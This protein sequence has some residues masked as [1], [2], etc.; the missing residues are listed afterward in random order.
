MY[1]RRAGP[2]APSRCH[3]NVTL[4]EGRRIQSQD[5][6]WG[7]RGD[8]ARRLRDDPK[9]FSTLAVTGSTWQGC[10]GGVGDADG[11]DRDGAGGDSDG[12]GGCNIGGPMVVMTMA[13]QR[14]RGALT[15]GISKKRANAAPLPTRRRCITVHRSE[16]AGCETVGGKNGETGGS[17]LRADFPCCFGATVMNA[18]PADAVTLPI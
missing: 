16:V 7:G 17:G 4:N 9:R 12:G 15:L 3:G 18:A 6:G 8:R 14:S 13:M 2:C 1:T 11:G 10:G 5:A